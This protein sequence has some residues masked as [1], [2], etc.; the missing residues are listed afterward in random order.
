MN[1]DAREL[2]AV[3]ARLERSLRILDV[4]PSE[5]IAILGIEDIGWPIPVSRQ[6]Q[7]FGHDQ[8]TRLRQLQET[9]DL[10]IAVFREDAEVLIRQADDAAGT[11]LLASLISSGETLPLLLRRL[12]EELAE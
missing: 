3:I 4:R 2:R 12:R 9:C 6:W 7:P 1:D 10:L 5:V 8:E 11:T